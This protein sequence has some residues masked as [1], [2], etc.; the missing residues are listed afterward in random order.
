MLN[1]KGDIPIIAMTANVM[2][3][4]VDKCFEAGMNGY[5]AK[6]FEPTDLVQQIGKTL[7]LTNQ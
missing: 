5:I 7:N 1:G 3:T 4:E 2:K 6:P